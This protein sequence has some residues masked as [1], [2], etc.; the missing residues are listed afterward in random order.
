MTSIF[1]SYRWLVQLPFLRASHAGGEALAKLNL[2]VRFYIARAAASESV[3]SGA[4]ARTKRLR[5]TALAQ[6]E[7]LQKLP[8]VPSDQRVTVRPS[9]RTK[10]RLP[11]PHERTVTALQQLHDS[12]SHACPPPLC[13]C[14]SEL[15]SSPSRS[16]PTNALSSQRFK[17]FAYG[18]LSI[19]SAVPC[20]ALLHCG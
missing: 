15:T 13:Y 3:A 12:C 1:G 5:P 20:I 7:L 14:S 10:A 9:A 18:Q 8:R 4:S 2:R 19:H 16:I 17:S 6:M 11:Q